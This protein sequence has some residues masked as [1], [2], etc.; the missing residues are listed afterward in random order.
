VTV[1][2]RNQRIDRVR[3]TLNRLHQIGA[4]CAGVVFNR[5]DP[6]DWAI[7][8]EGGEKLSTHRTVD[9]VPRSRPIKRSVDADSVAPLGRFLS[10]PSVQ[11]ADESEQRKR[12]A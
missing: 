3:Q 8:D 6:S 5:A 4:T 12:A 10:Q 11:N 7:V 9:L 2:E 1:V